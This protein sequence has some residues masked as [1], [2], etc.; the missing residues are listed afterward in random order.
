MSS[1]SRRVALFVGATLVMAV[2]SASPLTLAA[3]VS[4]SDPEIAAVGDIA[5]QSYSQGDGEGVCRSDE[6]AALITDLAPDR[7]LALGDLQYNI[8]KLSEF[9]RVYDRQFGHLLP[10]TLP[11]PG[12]HEYG[13]EDAQGYFDYFGE[14]AHGPEGYY[15]V[16][17]GAWHIVSLNSDICRDDPGCGPGTPQYEWLA[18]DLAGNDAE[19]TLAFQHHPVFDWRQWQKFV[20]PDDPRPNGGSENEMYLQLWRLLDREG[21][22]VMLVGHNHI[23][24]RWAPQHADGDRDPDGIRQF[25]VGTG[26]RSL[27][28]LGKKPRPENLLAVQNKAFGVL[29]MTL[30]EDSYDY[31]WVGLPTEPVF[32]DAGTVACR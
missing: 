26:G 6:V 14:R 21:V 24:H 17:L 2:T 4:R 22:D 3:A 29:Q 32:H 7:F 25:T 28:P 15:S 13:T 11:T 16:D 5:C 31:A 23:Y 27:Y 19:C 18:A 10:I 8:G 20:D 30:H 12:N 9:L 1:W